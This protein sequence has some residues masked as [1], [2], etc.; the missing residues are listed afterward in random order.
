MTNLEKTAHF[1]EVVESTLARIKD[2][3]VVKG[4]EYRRN[5]NPYHNFEEA[6]KENGLIREK[7]LDGMAVKHTVSINDMTNDL[8]RGVL[9]S[10]EQVE[11]K[12]N[13]AII[14]L[15][16]K[17]AS[18]LQRIEEKEIKDEVGD[19]FKALD[20]IKEEGTI[21]RGDSSDLLNF[22]KGLTQP[23]EEI[24]EETKEE[25]H[26]KS[27]ILVHRED[28]TKI[29]KGLHIKMYAPSQVVMNLLAC[30]DRNL[31]PSKKIRETIKKDSLEGYK[32]DRKV[33]EKMFLGIEL[34]DSVKARLEPEFLLTDLTML[35]S[36]FRVT[37]AETITLIY[38]GLFDMKVNVSD[39]E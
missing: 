13:D 27:S 38:P 1:D 15:I 21:Q 24:K 6:S 32:E 39:V 37:K 11:E 3:L 26:S 2:T 36:I 4:K 33:A 19:L 16:L 28:D 17:K 30:T 34:P 5:N 7:S 35:Q 10:K 31:L 14:Y 29:E 12:F 22:L 18:I 9:P 20:E 23:K 8:V 25:V